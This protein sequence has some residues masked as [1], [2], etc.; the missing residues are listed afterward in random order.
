[1]EKRAAG[2]FGNK[3]VEEGHF[4]NEKDY[5]FRVGVLQFLDVF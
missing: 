5:G 2:F 3:C 1:M 4:K